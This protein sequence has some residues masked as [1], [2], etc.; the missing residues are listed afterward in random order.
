MGISIV[1]GRLYDLTDA[2]G[3]CVRFRAQHCRYCTE[4]LVLVP[5]PSFLSGYYRI[6][7]ALTPEDISEGL[8][9]GYFMSFVDVVDALG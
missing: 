7:Q 1:F 8:N 5:T 4:R 2:Q 6:E 3:F 9:R